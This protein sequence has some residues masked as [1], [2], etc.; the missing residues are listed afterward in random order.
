M[1]Y[2][3]ILGVTQ[4]TKI[5]VLDSRELGWCYV[6]PYTTTPW[7]KGGKQINH[8]AYWYNAYQ[9]YD[10]IVYNSAE[11]ALAAANSKDS[12][13]FFLNEIDDVKIPYLKPRV[14]IKMSCGMENI[15]YF[16]TYKEAQVWTDK[17]LLEHKGLFKVI[18]ERDGI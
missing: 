13:E 3:E 5:K 14:F 1:G 2:K 17:L 6:G 11:D 4:I 10:I 8:S 15:I 18:E 7:W 9:S 12:K 16:D